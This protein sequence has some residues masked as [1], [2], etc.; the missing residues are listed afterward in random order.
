MITLMRF[1]FAAFMVA[2][3][4]AAPAASLGWADLPDPS[5]QD[6]EDPFRDL[7]P[8]QFDDPGAVKQRL[9]AEIFP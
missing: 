4:H 2:V 1:L 6:Y 9:D 8:E 5:V 7:S 3:A